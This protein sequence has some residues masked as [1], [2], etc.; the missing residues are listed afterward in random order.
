[1][2]LQIVANPTAYMKAMMV[3]TP[4]PI[5]E[6]MSLQPVSGLV[7]PAV[8]H[9]PLLF[10]NHGISLIHFAFI[11]SFCTDASLDDVMTA[12]IDLFLHECSVQNL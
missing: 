12:M 5:T 2:T 10:E 4:V 11:Q 1:M 3:A 9:M 7:S 6:M 8:D